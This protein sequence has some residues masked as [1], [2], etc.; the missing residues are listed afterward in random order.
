MNIVIDGTGGDHAPREVLLGAAAAVEELGVSI[1]VTG[2]ETEMKKCAEENSISL[3]G[4]TLVHAPR[5]ITMD[6]EPTRL[7]KDYSDCSLAVAMQMVADGRADAVVSAGSTG[8]LLVGA[9]FIVKRAKK[10]KRPAIGVMVPMTGGKFYLLVDAGASSDCR[11]EMICQYAVMGTAYSRQIMGTENP[12]VGLINNGTEDH[13]GTELQQQSY[14]LLKGMESINFIG[15]VE[16]RELPMG[17]CDIAV[18]DGFTGNV[19]LKLSEGFGSFF[20]ALLKQVFMTNAVTK[21]AALMVSAQIKS[22]KKSLDYKEYGGAP[23]LGVKK[24]VIKAHGDSDAR[25]FKNAIR[26]AK[27]CVERDV[28]GQIELGIAELKGKEKEEE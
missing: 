27:F 14:P 22:M 12:R 20:G 25:A 8:A 9:T 23:I 28:C 1:T 19:V 7:I 26:Q 21:M 17:G 2:D 13:K 11:P 24:P 15:N 6:I 18:C 5:V 16:A 4:I 3:N 10:V